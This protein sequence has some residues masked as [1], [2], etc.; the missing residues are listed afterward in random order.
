MCGSPPKPKKVEE[1]PPQY[2]RNPWLDGLALG[3]VG[4]S[5]SG[6]N[7]LRVDLGTPAGSAPNYGL[8]TPAAPQAPA[9]PS[10]AF[11]PPAGYTIPAY[12][13]LALRGAGG[14]GRAGLATLRV[15]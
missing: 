13:G 11:A 1:K 9:A 5:R 8:G 10:G 15:K 3:G 6:R 12:T 7:A 2:L 4:A 14:G